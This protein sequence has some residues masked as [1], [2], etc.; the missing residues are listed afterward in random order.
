MRAGLN[1][2]RLK[3]DLLELTGALRIALEELDSIE[4]WFAG[5]AVFAAAR[6]E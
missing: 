3:G 1:E 5:E 4:R 2:S 6:I